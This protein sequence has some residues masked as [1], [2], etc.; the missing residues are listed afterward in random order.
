M[1]SGEQDLWL[2]MLSV[3]QLDV[4]GLASGIL[5]EQRVEL[6]SGIEP[7]KG[8]S[9]WLLVKK[10]MKEMTDGVDLYVACPTSRFVDE[11][12]SIAAKQ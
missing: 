9:V 12:S 2:I 5:L 6:K 8:R 11:E 10:H 3:Q 1:H 4:S 7:H